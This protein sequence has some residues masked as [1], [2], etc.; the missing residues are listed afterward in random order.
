MIRLLQTKWMAVAIG[1][2]AYLATTWLCFQPQKHLTRIAAELRASAGA[3][4]LAS[5][6]PSWNFDNPE[7]AQLVAELK[8]QRESL[9]TRALQL[10]ELE[11]RLKAERQ[12]IYSVTQAVYQLKTNIEAS[13]TRVGEEE[14]VNLKKLAKV[15][16]AMTPENAARILREM[17]DDQIVK[18]LA[19][20][21]ETDSAPVLE[22]IGQGAKD[23]PKR[24]A[25]LTNRLRLTIL[26]A[27]SRK[28]PPP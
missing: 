7:M 11:A 8:D 27:G 15:Y 25:L 16:T 17:D 23:Q 19:L 26:S 18:I 22:L 14:A 4:H 3:N 6:G 2:V 5:S 21:K 12:E 1:A 24:A 28:V 20:M 13:I 9:R 10:D